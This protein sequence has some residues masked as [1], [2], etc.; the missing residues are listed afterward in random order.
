MPSGDVTE[1]ETFDQTW[2]VPDPEAVTD[3]AYQWSV[4]GI[5]FE[6]SVSG[7][8]LT[9]TPGPARKPIVTLSMTR[10][11]LDSVLAGEATLA[12]AVKAKEAT[13]TGPPD[14][15]RRMFLITGF[16]AALHGF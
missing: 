15:I 7:R 14:A 13:L 12:E 3:E 9:R 16:P 4:D 8:S 2:A 1:P 5:K 11:V 6:L 10:S